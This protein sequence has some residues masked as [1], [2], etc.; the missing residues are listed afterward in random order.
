MSDKQKQVASKLGLEQ[1]NGKV[2]LTKQ[3][4][5]T[6]IGGPLGI[7]EAIVP[8]TAFSVSFAI[9]KQAIISVSVA[10]ILALAFIGY[11]LI[12]KQMLSQ[13]VAGALGVG[14]AAFLALRDGG[15]AQDYFVPGF[16]TNASYGL[17]LLLSVVLRYPIMGFVIQFL[18]GKP[19]WRKD[20][21]AFRRATWVTLIWVGF[22][23]LRLL[24]Q[25]PLYF[26][27]QV[28][29][30]AASR[31]VM[32]AP[33]YAGLLVLTWVMLKRIAEEETE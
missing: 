14:L 2:A 15:S 4:L 20:K 23:G 16:I 26:T 32:G 11:R 21:T 10:A 5:L 33:A 18:F 22:F 31:V 25:L 24:V 3:S 17:V 28:E 6:A 9:S 29:L 7:A 12:R 8:A 27:G 19:G 1:A 30:L 13:A